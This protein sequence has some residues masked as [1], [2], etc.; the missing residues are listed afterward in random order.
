[1]KVRAV[2]GTLS[3]SGLGRA[4]RSNFGKTSRLERGISKKDLIAFIGCPW[5]LK[6][7]LWILFIL[8]GGC[9][10]ADIM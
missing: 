9:V 2:F 6:Y 5:I 4:L 10:G 1:M 3:D 8:K 7:L